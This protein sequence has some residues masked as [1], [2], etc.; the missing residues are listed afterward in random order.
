MVDFYTESCGWCKRLD[1]EVFPSPE[2]AE[3][4]RPFVPV[5]VDAEDGE[6]RPLARAVPG[7]TS[8]RCPTILFLDP[9][10]DDPKDARIVGKIPGFMPPSSFVEQLNVIARLPRDV[11]KLMEKVHPDDGDAMR[12]LA[13]ALAMQGRVKEAAAL[14]DRAWGPGADPNFDRWAA[15]YNT[16]GDDEAMHAPEAGARPPNGTARRPAW[17]SGRSTSTTPTWAPASSRRLQR[18]GDA[19][20]PGARS[21]RT[22]GRR[23]ERRTRIRQGIAEQPSLGWRAEAAAVLKR[24]KAKSAKP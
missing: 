6:G 11:G 15:V 9:A 20:R 7:C 2:V 3:A 21:G 22:G 4:M 23:L 12:R 1:A 5:K 14:I 13:T 18:K 10:I 19:S 8:E 17:R 16:I 24:L